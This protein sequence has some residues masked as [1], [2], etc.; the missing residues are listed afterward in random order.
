MERQERIQNLQRLC[1][2]QLTQM[3][4]D[5][6]QLEPVL[7]NLSDQMDAPDFPAALNR[8]ME[9]K[10][11]SVPRLCELAQ[12]S[13]AF[14]YQLCSGARMPG[15]DIVLRLALVLEL[16]VADAQRLLAAA[17]RGALYPRVRRDAILIFC[18]EHRCSLYDS[19]ELLTTYG[20]T[21]L[22]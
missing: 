4:Q 8:H 7:G 15:R 18:L 11:I 12:L 14:A 6:A 21:P 10:Q 19:D 2:K 16:G 9:E 3:L 20:E 13:R 22:L 17:N 1:T 5:A